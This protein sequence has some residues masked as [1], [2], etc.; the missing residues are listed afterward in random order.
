[1]ASW[2][3]FADKLHHGM[4]LKSKVKPAIPTDMPCSSCSAAHHDRELPVRA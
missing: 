4:K 3:R 2:L 1:M